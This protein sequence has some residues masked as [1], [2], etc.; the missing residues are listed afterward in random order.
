VIV[1]YSKERVRGQVHFDLHGIAGRTVHLHDWMDDATYTRDGSE[2]VDEH[3]G[4]FV[5]LAPWQ[6]HVFQVTTQGLWRG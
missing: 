3:R 1:N 6:P 2:L 5:D 4:L